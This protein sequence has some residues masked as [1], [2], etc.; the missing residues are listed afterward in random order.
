MNKEGNKKEHRYLNSNIWDLDSILEGCLD[1]SVKYRNDLLDE[2]VN[3]PHVRVLRS[4]TVIRKQ[5]LTLDLQI[6]TFR[7]KNHGSK[8]FNM[9][10]SLVLTICLILWLQAWLLSQTSWAQIQALPFMSLV[11]LFM[12]LVKLIFWWLSFLVCKSI[13]FKRLL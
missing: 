7:K 13:H 1:P 4:W 3:F 2:F 9:S 10:P 6:I 8:N 11:K 12:S 5:P